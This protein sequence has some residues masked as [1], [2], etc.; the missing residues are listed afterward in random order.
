MSTNISTTLKKYR[1][2]NNFSQA[3]VA[4]YLGISASAY[5]HYESGNREPN[6]S[7]LTNLAKLYH[8]EDQILGVYKNISSSITIFKIY[9]MNELYDK[10]DCS[11][12]KYT[13]SPKYANKKIKLLPSQFEALCDYFSKYSD[14]KKSV[15]TDISS[16]KTGNEGKLYEA[17]TYAWLERQGIP[18][19]PQETV[20]SDECLNLHGYNADG[21]IE[22]SVIFDVKM[23]GITHPNIRRLEEKLNKMNKKNRSE[24]YIAISDS[25]DLSNDKMQELLSTS[26]DIYHRLFLDENKHL[27]DYWYTIP[28]T[29]LKVRAHD[30]KDIKMIST[31]SEF[32][33]YKWAMENQ[34]YF[35]HDASQFC[36]QKPFIII[37]PYD[38]KTAQLFTGSFQE[39]TMAAF[40]SICRRMFLG[41]SDDID[42]KKYD[43]KCPPIISTK[44]ASQC[45]SAVIF[46]DISMHSNNDDT[47]IFTNPNARNK[48]PKYVVEKFRYH[49][50]SFW[51]DFAYDVYP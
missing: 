28:E 36:T 2:I 41:M 27:T 44:A 40:R 15:F 19:N 14:Y 43:Q 26:D 49:M 3:E 37:C 8:L 20:S 35:F 32:N 22:G 46:Q 25:M 17:L 34:Y 31:I 1:Q 45:I 6:I 50:H 12:G 5:N 10:I 7:V 48:V 29:D 4:K 9:T 21:I 47:W 16:S 33:P 23:F 13:L 11:E 38:N 42:V 18:F 39:S 51:E 24:Y 30:T